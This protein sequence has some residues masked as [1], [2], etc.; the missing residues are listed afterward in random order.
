MKRFAW[1][2]GLLLGVGIAVG[3]MA[4]HVSAMRFTADTAK[5]DVVNSSVY[6]AGSTV[7]LRGEINGDVFCAGQSI[8][9]DAV[10]H[11]DIICAGQDVTIDGEVDGDIRVAGQDVSISAKVTRSVTVAASK[12]SLDAPAT[13]GRDI[14]TFGSN[15]HL[16]GQTGRDALI[17]GGEAIIAGNVGGDVRFEGTQLRVNSATIA[18]GLTNISSREVKREGDTT[19]ARGIT[20]KKPEQRSRFSFNFSWFVFA[21]VSLSLMALAVALIA[22]RTLHSL[23]NVIGSVWIKPLLVGFAA[24]LMLPFLIAVLCITVVGIP[25]GIAALVAWLGLLLLSGPVVAYYLGRRILAKQPNV[26]VRSL[27][28]CA[29]LVIIYFIPFIGFIVMLAVYWTGSGALLLAA[30]RR[31]GSPHY[32]IK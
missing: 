32:T 9:I 7:T 17:S 25:L 16:K 11:G 1:G 8:D 18:G 28:G 22:P 3:G 26:L 27:V 31:L 14:T 20:D 6:A 12:F 2:I 24:S 19:I 5:D 10:V 15:V 13:I 29:I 30:Q 23:S 4:V 21:L